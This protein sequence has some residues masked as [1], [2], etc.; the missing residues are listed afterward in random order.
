[1]THRKVTRRSSVMETSAIQGR[2]LIDDANATVRATG[3]ARQQACGAAAYVK[4][5][6]QAKQCAEVKPR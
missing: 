1:M 6:G 2:R 3:F 4:P 5:S